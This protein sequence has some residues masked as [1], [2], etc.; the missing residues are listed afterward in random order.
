MLETWR[1]SRH[2][3]VYGALK[4]IATSYQSCEAGQRPAMTS[5]TRNVEGIS[6]VGTHPNGVGRIR[7]ISDLPRLLRT[8]Y[9]LLSYER[10]SSSCFKIQS[11]PLI[12][13]YGGK[14][15]TDTGTDAVLDLFRNAGTGGQVLGIDC[16]GYVYSALATAGLKLKS[17]GR[18]KA[19]GVHGV[20]ASM[21]M[22]PRSNGLTCL[23]LVTFTSRETL[24]PGDLLASS[25]HVVMIE[26]VGPD[27]L[28]IASITRESDCKRTNISLSRLDF[29]I[30]QSSPSKGGIGINHMRAAD[31]LADGGSMATA[32]IEHAV[33]ACLAKFRGPIVSKSSSANLVRH[34]GTSECLDRPV[35]LA[36]EECIAGCA[37]EERSA[38]IELP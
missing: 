22:N 20:N 37:T 31:Y 30:L 36:R 4:T 24:K 28:G 9:Y 35:R 10:P 21:L 11:S 7:A 1:K 38:D 34:K 8:D 26:S 17:S 18:L 12:Y 25:G 5:D 6:I 16:S 27:P 32:M 3:A 15:S 2:P 33:N 14:P 29:T 19:I 13:D 23:D